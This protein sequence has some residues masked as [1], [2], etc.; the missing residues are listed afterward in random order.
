M[1]KLEEG[2][3][4]LKLQRAREKGRRGELKSKS[5]FL[6]YRLMSKEDRGVFVGFRGRRSAMESFRR[7]LSEL[8]RAFMDDVEREEMVLLKTEFYSGKE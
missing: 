6:P 2:T 1:Q 8:Q 7:S 4:R 3:Y 5:D